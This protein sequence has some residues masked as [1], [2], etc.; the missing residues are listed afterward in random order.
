MLKWG[1]MK[2]L[3]SILLTFLVVLLVF[4]VAFS[5]TFYGRSQGWFSGRAPADPTLVKRMFEAL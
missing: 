1:V 5:L 2:T 4:A 3:K